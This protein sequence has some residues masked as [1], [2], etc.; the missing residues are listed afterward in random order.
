[1]FKSP[2]LII[3]IFMV[4]PLSYGLEQDH[5]PHETR[6]EKGMEVLERMLVNDQKF[7]LKNLDDPSPE[8]A[9]WA[10][11]FAHGGVVSR[12]KV[13]L[14]TREL[15]SVSALTAMGTAEPQPKT[16]IG[17]ELNAGTTASKI[18]EIII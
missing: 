15:T 13:D 14:R 12:S 3:I 4:I 1:M 9:R 2:K 5:A 17:M 8:M 18:L 16:H 7:I 11:D 10:I 6:A